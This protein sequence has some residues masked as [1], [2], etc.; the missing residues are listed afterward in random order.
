MTIPSRSYLLKNIIES[1]VDIDK[2]SYDD[3]CHYMLDSDG[4]IQAIE[5]APTVWS[6][7]SIRWL[8]TSRLDLIHDEERGKNTTLAKD[9]G[10]QA[11]DLFEQSAPGEYDAILMDVMMPNVDGLTTARIIRALDRPDVETVPILALTANAFA[12]DARKCLDADMNAHLAK[13]LNMP[14][15]K[16]TIAKFTQ[17]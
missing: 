9:S 1:G 3:L 16:A 6:S 14:L 8:T 17:H 7:R 2:S 10:R 13:P 4:I 12:E 15:V 11:I 5:L